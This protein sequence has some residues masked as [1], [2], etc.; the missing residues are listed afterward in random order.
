MASATRPTVLLQQPSWCLCPGLLCSTL[1][2]IVGEASYRD[3]PIFGMSSV[4]REM[5]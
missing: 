2:E 5:E 1:P 3:A 4:H